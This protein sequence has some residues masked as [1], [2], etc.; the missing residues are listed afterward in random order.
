MA[1]RPARIDPTARRCPVPMSP[2]AYRR[3]TCSLQVMTPPPAVG[4]WP[5][6]LPP[7]PPPRGAPHPPLP[8][9]TP[10]F[11]GFFGCRCGSVDS[12]WVTALRGFSALPGAFGHRW[13][14]QRVAPAFAALSW[15]GAL[16][17]LGCP[18][19]IRVASATCLPSSVRCPHH[20]EPVFFRRWPYADRLPD[21]DDVHSLYLL[22]QLHPRLTPKHDPYDCGVI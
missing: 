18:R 19:G 9:Q 16:A 21:L 14:R 8:I 13:L 10:V 7:A 3:V 11:F 1:Q 17:S 22:F 2:T 5:M 15:A 12:S 6:P 4:Q 20:I